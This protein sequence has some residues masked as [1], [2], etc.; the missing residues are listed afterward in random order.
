[1]IAVLEGKILCED[2][3]SRSRLGIHWIY[4]DLCR[5]PFGPVHLHITARWQLRSVNDTPLI[6][7]HL[8]QKTSFGGKRDASHPMHVPMYCSDRSLPL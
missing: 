5:L 2:L 4:A 3:Q 1:M 8:L 6:A 7:D